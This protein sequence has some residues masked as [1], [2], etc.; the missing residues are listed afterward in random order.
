MDKNKNK[1]PDWIENVIYWSS[2][3]LLLSEAYKKIVKGEKLTDA[4]DVTKGVDY[5]DSSK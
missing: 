2:T 5:A 4:F 3:I 1:V